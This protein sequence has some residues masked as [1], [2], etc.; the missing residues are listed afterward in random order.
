MSWH[1]LDGDTGAVQLSVSRMLLPF[2]GPLV[3]FQLIYTPVKLSLGWIPEF[4]AARL[5]NKHFTRAFLCFVCTR[6][7]CACVWVCGKTVVW[8]LTSGEPVGS[9]KGL[10]HVPVP[11][12]VRL[13]SSGSNRV[14][15]YGKYLPGYSG[16]FN[17]AVCEWKRN[18][19]NVWPACAK[20]SLKLHWRFDTK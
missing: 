5:H 7:V 13:E 20:V 12:G 3:P 18:S 14:L 17:R 2:K 15:P 4:W 10:F 1:V 16:I 6:S 11:S 19:G 9:M 8:N